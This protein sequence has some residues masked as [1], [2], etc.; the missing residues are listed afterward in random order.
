MELRDFAELLHTDDN[1]FDYRAYATLILTTE[2]YYPTEEEID[3]FADYLAIQDE[4]EDQM[5][6]EAELEELYP[7]EPTVNEIWDSYLKPKKCI[8]YEF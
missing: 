7:Y 4:I 8:S 1:T 2:D 6:I 3:D 5:T